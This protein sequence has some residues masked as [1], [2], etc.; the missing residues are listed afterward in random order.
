[1][2]RVLSDGTLDTASRDGSVG[3]FCAP[4]TV[5]DVLELNPG[6]TAWLAKRRRT[7]EV[8]LLML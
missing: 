2:V 5:R 1:M 6:D 8:I 3:T 7:T 4:S